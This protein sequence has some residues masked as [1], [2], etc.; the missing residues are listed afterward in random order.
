MPNYESQNV[1]K[2]ENEFV[3]RDERPV[4]SQEVP[5][6]STRKVKKKGY[7]S[8][9]CRFGVTAIAAG[10]SQTT[11]F[12]VNNPS[13]ATE[14]VSG[15]M[16]ISLLTSTTWSEQG[17]FCSTGTNGMISGGSKT[18]S[19]TLDRVRI[20]TVS[21]DTFDAGSINIMYE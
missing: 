17:V 4:V 3:S 12:V 11:G 15:Q 9:S 7:N 1:S 2:M 14:T 5:Q 19:G 6:K 21:G 20:T 16:M 10:N 8:F 13:S 18:L